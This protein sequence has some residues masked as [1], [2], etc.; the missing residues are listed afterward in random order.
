MSPTLLVHG[1]NLHLAFIIAIV[2]IVSL[3]RLNNEAPILTFAR[4]VFIVHQVSILVLSAYIWAI[5]NDIKP[6][7]NN[8]E[9]I[10]YVLEYRSLDNVEAAP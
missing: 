7:G 5:Q 6:S 1:W 8:W 4:F 9:I 3:I 2:I 10:K